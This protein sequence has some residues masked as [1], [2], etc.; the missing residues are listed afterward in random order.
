MHARLDQ[1]LNLRDGA[2]VDAQVRIHVQHCAVCL[3][4]SERLAQVG[5]RLRALPPLDP[6]RD[7]WPDIEAR[8]TARPRRSRMGIAAAAAALVV[9]II[10]YVSVHHESVDAEQFTRAPA[11]QP[12]KEDELARLIEQSREL[13]AALAYLPARPQVER[14]STAAT[15][16]SLEQRIQWVDWQLANGPDMGLDQ[17][18]AER[19]WSERV[20]L[21]D[22]LVKVRYA[23]SAPMVF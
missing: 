5:D 15:V 3:A 11:S 10:G 13:E 16:D 19:L 8:A 6:P 20:D 9:A 23:E 4:E 2:P 18:Q 1:L 12:K 22:S 7:F 21:M 14:V 17:R